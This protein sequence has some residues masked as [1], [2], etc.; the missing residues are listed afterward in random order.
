MNDLN[1]F[2]IYQG[3]NREQKD[4]KMYLY[5]MV[6]ILLG[7]IVLTFSINIFRI[8]LLDKEIKVYTEKLGASEIQSQLKEADE[9]NSKID[10]LSKYEGAL[11]DVVKST[12][13][14]DI[15]TDD[16]L[17]DICNA[18]PS[19]I[20]FKDLD[21]QGYDVKINGT[22]HTRAAVGEFEHNL[23]ELSKVKK[24]HVNKIAKSNTPG[25][26]YTFEILCVLKE[27]E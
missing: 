15:V 18:I 22:T 25:E 26:E 14:N 21:A 16:L 27:V 20:S 5:A 19:D 2:S 24:V 8:V 13:K 10:M 3:S 12:E 6:G 11:S 4:E 17:N 7:I 9:V 23:G 1:F